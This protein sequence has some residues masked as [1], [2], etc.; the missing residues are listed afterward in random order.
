MF[1]RWIW[2]ALFCLLGCTQLYDFDAV[3]A[4]GCPCSE[5]YV[6]I[7]GS[8]QC[9]REGSVEEGKSCAGTAGQGDALCTEGY[10][11]VDRAG[12]GA[13]RCL[14][15]C[16]PLQYTVSGAGALEEAQCG[17]GELC[18]PFSG[19]DIKGVCDP[20][21]CDRDENEACA[22]GAFCQELNGAGRCLSSCGSFLGGAGARCAEGSCMPAM[23]MSGET[24]EDFACFSAGAQKVNSACS[25]QKPCVAEE[26]G[27][28]VLCFP[29]GQDEASKSCGYACKRKEDCPSGYTVCTP[30][31]GEIGRCE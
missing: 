1:K 19:D 25:A 17:S 23:P 11:C 27:Q 4:L 6:C 13:A 21:D 18:W 5:G 31:Y 9:V 29:V 16:A 28:A 7:V 10:A 2:A 22:D 14:K 12:D 20:G 24:P 15:P 3:E 30:Q 8:D 26:G